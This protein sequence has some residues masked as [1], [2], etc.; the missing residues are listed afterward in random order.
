MFVW[1]NRKIPLVMDIGCGPGNTAKMLAKMLSPERIVGLDIDAQMI[2]FAKEN[3]AMPNTEYHC[4][5]ISADMSEWSEDLRQLCGK[6]SVIFSNYAL[7]WVKDVER[8]AHNM[9]RL[10][11]TGGQIV[12]DILYVGDIFHRLRPEERQQYEQWLS[13][14]SEQQVI[15]RWVTAFK[16]AGL[17]HIELKYWKPTCIYP[18]KLYFDGK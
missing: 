5:D 16:S 18:L 11:A 1:E 10:L 3:N 12:V 9:A 2:G 7:H 13:Y 17:N 4:Q 8:T 6:V 15:G 14:P